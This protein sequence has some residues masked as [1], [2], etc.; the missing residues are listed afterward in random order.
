[1][2][3]KFLQSVSGPGVNYGYGEIAEA[4]D[5]PNGDAARFLRAG[6]AVPVEDRP[7]T[8]EAPRQTVR[9]AIKR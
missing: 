9:K 5:I 4:A 1:M 3:I 7:D 8:T 6:I 2:K